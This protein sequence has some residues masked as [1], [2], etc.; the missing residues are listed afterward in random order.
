MAQVRKA[1]KLARLILSYV[2][3][4][5]SASLIGDSLEW[6]TMPSGDGLQGN[7]HCCDLI[8][9]SFSTSNSSITVTASD[10]VIHR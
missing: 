5:R 4:P 8:A 7:V 10:I 9:L 2:L 6:G 3:V 1:P